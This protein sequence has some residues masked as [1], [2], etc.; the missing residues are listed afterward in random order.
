VS[1]TVT[2]AWGFDR[3]NGLQAVVRGLPIVGRHKGSPYER[4]SSYAALSRSRW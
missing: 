4:N 3:H 2:R 1:R